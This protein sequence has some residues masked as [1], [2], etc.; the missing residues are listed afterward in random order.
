MATVV[1]RKTCSIAASTWLVLC[2]LTMICSVSLA[3]RMLKEKEL[4]NDGKK[5]RQGVLEAIANFLW[6]EGKSSYEPVWPVSSSNT[7]IH[8][9]V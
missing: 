4:G 3:D 7:S 9:I 2:I 1:K 8:Y 5:E 6:E